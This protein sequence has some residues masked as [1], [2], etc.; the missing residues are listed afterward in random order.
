MKNVP[1]VPRPGYWNVLVTCIF[2]L[3]LSIAGMA[4]AAAAA[5]G[6]WAAAA[7]AAGGVATA[8]AGCNALSAAA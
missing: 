6:G 5:A 8:G 1:A 2:T 7:A 4:A 3:V